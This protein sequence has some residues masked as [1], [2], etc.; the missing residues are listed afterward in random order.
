MSKFKFFVSNALTWVHWANSRITEKESHVK[1]KENGTDAAL[2]G[3]SK[4]WECPDPEED[5]QSQ[6]STSF[7]IHLISGG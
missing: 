6:G 1:N 2:L 7:C 3:E 4:H 5:S